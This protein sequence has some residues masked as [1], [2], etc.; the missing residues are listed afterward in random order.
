MK[1][2]SSIRRFFR[3]YSIVLLTVFSFIWFIIRTGTKPSRA[4]Y[5]CQR[6]AAAQ[7][8]V[9][10][11]AA[12]IPSLISFRLSFDSIRK[13]ILKIAPAV[14]AGAILIGGITAYNQY[15]ENKLIEK[16]KGQT[17]PAMSAAAFAE[18]LSAYSAPD[19]PYLIKPDDAV[20]SFA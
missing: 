9:V 10:L 17:I 4:T 6:A 1:K 13:N 12:L 14:L 2:I 18:A 20:V 3:R 16:L 8:A 19:S 7:M 15:K 11:N 5:P